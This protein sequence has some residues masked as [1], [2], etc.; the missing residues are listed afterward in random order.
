MQAVLLGM[1]RKMLDVSLAEAG[2]GL[3]QLVM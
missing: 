1:A 2:L 3:S